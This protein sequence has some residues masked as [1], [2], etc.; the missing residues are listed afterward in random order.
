MLHCEHFY[1]M[2]AT[3]EPFNN[4]SSQGVL[5]VISEL[6]TW[7]RPSSWSSFEGPFLLFSTFPGSMVFIV[8]ATSCEFWCILAVLNGYTGEDD[9][10]FRGFWCENNRKGLVLDGFGM[11]WTT[12]FK[13]E[14]ICWNSWRKGF[15]VLIYRVCSYIKGNALFPGGWH[16]GSLDCWNSI[17]IEIWIHQK[18]TKR[19]DWCTVYKRCKSFILWFVLGFGFSSKKHSS[20]DAIKIA[21]HVRNLELGKIW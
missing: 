21:W 15:G 11:T 4:R 2:C 1:S 14:A 5:Q 18:K 17:I 10:V 20:Y 6:P 16:K 9:G 8:S 7:T 19:F 3:L 13:P 12:P